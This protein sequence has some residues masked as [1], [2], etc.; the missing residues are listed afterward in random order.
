MSINNISDI[1]NLAYEIF[2]EEFKTLKLF[3]YLTPPNSTDFIN[4]KHYDTSFYKKA[5]NILRNKKLESLMN[6]DNEQ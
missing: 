4:E 2:I 6:H 3:E 1:D 5:K